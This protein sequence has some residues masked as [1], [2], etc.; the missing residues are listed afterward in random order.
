[1][2]L[3]NDTS[4]RCVCNA[5]FEGDG[6]VCAGK[7]GWGVYTHNNELN[8][9]FTQTSR[10]TLGSALLACVAGRIV[11]VG[12]KILTVESEYGR[13]GGGKLGVFGWKLEYPSNT[14]DRTLVAVVTPNVATKKL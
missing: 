6:N 3:K 12:G 14:L 4:G 1:M 11:R 10:S 7:R 9:N 13:G 5:G 8:V 2:I